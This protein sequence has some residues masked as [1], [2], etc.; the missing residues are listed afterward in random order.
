MPPVHVLLSCCGHCIVSQKFEGQPLG[1]RD[2]TLWKRDPIKLMIDMLQDPDH[3][4]E[5]DWS[6]EPPPGVGVYNSVTSGNW[7]RE[8]KVSDI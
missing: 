7:Y 6:G 3:C 2:L 4:A 1:L 8:V 5:I